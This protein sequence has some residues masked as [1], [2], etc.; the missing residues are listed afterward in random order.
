[1]IINPKPGNEPDQNDMAGALEG[2]GEG[3][4][5]SPSGAHVADEAE[6]EG[7]RLGGLA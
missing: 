3:Q 7:T 4:H 5:V 1:M 6:E 2:D